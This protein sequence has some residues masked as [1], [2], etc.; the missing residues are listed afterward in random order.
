MPA[1]FSTHDCFVI[2][3]I[4]CVSVQEGRKCCGEWDVSWDKLMQAR[5]NASSKRIYKSKASIE[6]ENERWREEE[7]L[8]IHPFSIFRFQTLQLVH[9]LSFQIEV[10]NA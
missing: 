4:F 3:D 6:K 1:P 7:G 8:I 10:Q 9:V 5:G 2:A